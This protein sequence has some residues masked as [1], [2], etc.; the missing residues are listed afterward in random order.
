MKVRILEEEIDITFNVK[1]QMAYEQITGKPFD[2]E[3]VETVT[4]MTALCMA[5]VFVAKPTTS[6]SLDSLMEKASSSEYLQLRQAVLEEMRIW[7]QMPE[8][9]T[10]EEEEEKGEEGESEPKN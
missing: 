10:K 6:I 3:V 2:K 9:L 5:A 8:T 7:Y 4:N 1:V